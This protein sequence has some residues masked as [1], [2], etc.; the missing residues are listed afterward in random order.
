METVSFKLDSALARE[1]ERGMKL[2]HYSTK[3]EFIRDSIRVRLEM[4]AEEREKRAAWQ[5]LYALRGTFK[6]KV[7][8]RTKEEERQFE[9]KFDREMRAHYEKKFGIKLT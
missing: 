1:I 2:S 3:T 4:L 6:G 8:V 5:S 9:K 7:P